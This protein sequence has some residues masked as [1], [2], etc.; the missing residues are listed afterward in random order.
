MFWKKITLR[1]GYETLL[2]GTGRGLDEYLKSRTVSLE[3]KFPHWKS[4]RRT[5]EKK[6]SW[7]LGTSYFPLTLLHHFGRL[8]ASVHPDRYAT[9]PQDSTRTST[10]NHEPKACAEFPNLD[11]IGRLF[12]VHTFAVSF[13]RL[14]SDSNHG[15]FIPTTGLEMSENHMPGTM[16]EQS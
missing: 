15:T 9:R 13:Y 6:L 12:S 10:R 11:F 7:I 16:N 14:I 3:G 5:F 2:R 8:S 4:P 1:S